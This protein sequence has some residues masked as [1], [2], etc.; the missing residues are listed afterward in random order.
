[1]QR[2]SIVYREH[3][4]DA[5][6]LAIVLERQIAVS[7]IATARHLVD[8]DHTLPD[9]VLHSDLMVVLGGDGTIL[10]CARQCATSQTPILGVNFGHVGFLAE[11]EPGEA[12][13][14]IGF[15]LRGDYWTDER[16]MLGGVLEMDGER[17]EILALNDVVMARG[18]EPRIVRFTISIGNAYYTA[19]RAD[20]VIVATATGST[21]YNLAAGGPILYPSVRGM[22]VTPI[23]PH[24]AIDRPLILE[25]NETV[26]LDIASDSGAAVLAADGQTIWPLHDDAS[27]TIATSPHLTRFVRRNPRN[28][29]YQVLRDKLRER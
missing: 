27:V 16:T 22:V 20:G 1:M 10:S 29:F 3:L 6:D 5:V 15:Y 18:A 17:R 7:G 2:V 8:R 25:P 28:H 19:L 9:D 24:L 14:E 4:P 12:L 23:A 11:L 13:G 21:G 26:R